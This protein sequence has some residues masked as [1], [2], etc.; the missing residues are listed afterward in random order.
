MIIVFLFKRRKNYCTTLYLTVMS[1][2]LCFSEPS[3]MV[4]DTWDAC[5]TESET[6]WFRRSQVGGNSNSNDALK[7]FLN[8][9]MRV[10]L[11]GHKNPEQTKQDCIS[12]LESL[13]TE[14]FQYNGEPHPPHL[15]CHHL[16]H[17]FD[18]FPSMDVSVNMFRD[19]TTQTGIFLILVSGRMEG[20]WLNQ[21]AT[22]KQEHLALT[23]HVQAAGSK[24][25]KASF[26][27]EFLSPQ[28]Y[29]AIRALDLVFTAFSIHQEKKEEIEAPPI[30]LV[31][32]LDRR[33]EP[34]RFEDELKEAEKE[35]ISSQQVQLE[36]PQPKTIQDIY[37]EQIIAAEE[38]PI[39]DG[40]YAMKGFVKDENN[41]NAQRILS[42]L[43]K[44]SLSSDEIEELRRR[45]E[46]IRE[47][48]L[49]EGGCGGCGG[50]SSYWKKKASVAANNLVTEEEVLRTMSG[51]VNVPILADPVSPL[52]MPQPPVQNGGNGYYAAVEQVPIAGQP[53]YSGYSTCCPP[54]FTTD[55]TDYD[56]NGYPQRGGK[57]KQPS[58][59]LSTYFQ[60]AVKSMSRTMD[61]NR[62]NVNEIV[63]KNV[64]HA[65]RSLQSS[66]KKQS[67][68][69]LSQD[70]GSV[71]GSLGTM[72]FPQG[73]VATVTPL[74]LILGAKLTQKM[75]ADLK[76]EKKEKKKPMKKA[77]VS[78]MPIAKER[79]LPKLTKTSRPM[80]N[81]QI[82]RLMRKKRQRGGC[83]MN[84]VCG[85]HLCGDASLRPFGD[86]LPPT[87]GPKC[88]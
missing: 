41:Q 69:L 19:A 6:S 62:E 42:L 64:T 73:T 75:N 55:G 29:Q 43:Q 88:F 60:Q 16:L 87:W 21:P 39:K 34:K 31:A 81:A 8:V 46:Y 7:E 9:L 23:I 33:D 18:T 76:K 82:R 54:Y 49:Q 72:I 56:V 86:C 67:S 65:M 17:L 32:V 37:Q 45:Q 3:S 38:L 61:P 66:M 5:P 77:K 36:Q 35:Y 51:G 53:V 20:G 47:E 44:P 52:P 68:R 80:S 30:K 71:L 59:A 63:S 26:R 15:L 14:D 57:A 22:N 12:A 11:E 27:S 13:V 50:G 48:K 58:T 70:G 40:I 84:D 1:R 78:K 79:E 28:C 25:Q 24:V 2:H 4:V 85:Q 10:L 74:L 83:G